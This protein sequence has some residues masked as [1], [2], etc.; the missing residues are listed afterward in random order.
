MKEETTATEL[1]YQAPSSMYIFFWMA[2]IAFVVSATR[3]LFV[4]SRTP[5]IQQTNFV[6]HIWKDQIFNLFFVCIF[7]ITLGILNYI[8]SE[9]TPPI[10]GEVFILTLGTATA[11]TLSPEQRIRGT[12]CFYIRT[13]T[14]GILCL[15]GW[16]ITVATAFGIQYLLKIVI[17]MSHNDYFLI[18]FMVTGGLW[19]A[20]PMLLYKKILYSEELRPN[21]KGN[22]FHKFLWPLL[23]AYLSLLI[24]LLVQEIANSEKW[25]R[26]TNVKPIRSVQVDMSDDKKIFP[27]V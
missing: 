5:N 26:M 10:Y 24:P 17:L 7:S 13:I 8:F 23:F 2:G 19:C 14:F 25:R 12:L 22:A 1:I 21:L 3:W 11:F 20:P 15:I 18:T 16:G 27:F 6:T 4:A 9:P